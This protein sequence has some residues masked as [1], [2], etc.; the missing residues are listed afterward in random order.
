MTKAYPV[1][2]WISRTFLNTITATGTGNANEPMRF[3]SMLPSR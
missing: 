2:N 3:L 1:G